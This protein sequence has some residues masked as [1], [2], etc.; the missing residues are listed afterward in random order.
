MSYYTER[1]GLRTPVA[2]TES[3]TLEMYQTIFDCC[4]K[5]FKNIAYLYPEECPDGNGCCGL[6]NNKFSCAMT[7]EI[8]DLYKNQYGV[9]SKPERNYYDTPSFDQY[10]LLDLIELIYDKMKDIKSEWWHS[11]HRHYDLSFADTWNTKTVYRNEINQIFKKTGLLYEL[12]TNGMVERVILNGTL[13]KEIE[14]NVS[15]INEKGTKELLD[16]AIILFKQPNPLS[17]NDAVEKIW[18]ALERLKTYYTSLD[19][20]SSV[21]KI[22]FDMANTQKEFIELFNT[23]FKA[24]TDIGNNFR[25]RHHETNK[26]DITDTKHCDYFFNRCLSLIAL[27]IQY[28]H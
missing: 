14:N 7:F 8:P 12:S 2:F 25:I 27:A 23:E 15:Q 3:M 24:L 13:T 16:E 9:V 20:K 5:Y 18:D 1:H 17:R 21:N 6:D 19:K 26:I 4:E 28:L 22:V 10:A 11:F